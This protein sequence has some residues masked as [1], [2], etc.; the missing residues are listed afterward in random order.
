LAAFHYDEALSSSVPQT[1]NYAM[2]KQL[3]IT[4]L[5]A[6]AT[7]ASTSAQEREAYESDP[8]NYSQA[9]PRDA[10]AALQNRIASGQLSLGHDDRDTVRALLKEFRVPVESQVLVFSKTS[11]QRGRIR[12]DHP[13]SIFFT[14]DCYLGWVPSG[15]IEITTIDPVL[16]PIF[17]AFN[18]AASRTNPSKCV[19]RDSDCLRCH[20]G[21]FVRGIPGVF[22]RSA[23]TDAEGEPM[24]R[25]GSEVVDYRTSF[26]NRW[27]GWY[28]TGKHGSAFHR[29]NILAAEKNDRL[30]ADF[31]SGAN[32]TNLSKFFDPSDYMTDSSDIVAL[33]VLEHQTAMQNTLTK[34]SL[35]SRRMLAYQK[36]LQRE[37]R[38]PIT[39][40]AVY[41]SVK[42][43]LD[44]S[45]REIVDDLLFRGEAELPAGLEGGAPF[46]T[47][48]RANARHASDGSSL[49]DFVLQ[50][51]IFKNRC[52]YLIYSDS[53]LSL[54]AQ[55]KRRVY[56]RLTA[57][58]RP[59]DA[60]PRYAYLSADERARILEILRQT[61]PEF[62]G[63]E[64]PLSVIEKR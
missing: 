25:Y 20:G 10:V 51:H 14:E 11:L 32:V 50:G 48:F 24:L 57:A 2:K 3:L 55:L 19:E 31:R 36:N 30:E 54:P 40:E 34:A 5:A 33:L 18:P 6:L 47:A 43:V 56:N 13:R 35:N 49:K 7:C 42:S 4:G 38:E 21:T 26:T 12:P 44:S 16:G 37:L 46:Q 27:G 15:L 62:P 59:A 58:L 9:K 8:I 60:D 17:Y 39:E 22:V 63:K 41:D 61:H 64:S 29:G 1:L 52:S 28:V 23:F 45:A 53:L